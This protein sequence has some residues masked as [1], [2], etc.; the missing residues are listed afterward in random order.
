MLTVSD[1]L[2][3][4]VQLASPPNIYFALREV[5]ED[6]NKTVQDAA[7]VIESDAALAMKLLKIVNSAFYGFPAQISSIGKAISLIGLRELQNMVLAALVIERFSEL[8]GAQLS[9]HDFW[10]KNLRSAL[11]A[12]ELDCLCGKQYA[13]TA[14]LCGLVHNIG[15]LVFY[16]RIPLL[17]RQVD[18]ELQAGLQNGD[19]VAIQRQVIGLDQY[20][21]GSE[22]CRMWQLPEVVGESIA[23]HQQRD[24]NSPFADIAMIVSYANQLA[25]IEAV[26]RTQIP[27]DLNL[28][29]D[30]ISSLLDKTHEEFEVL[31][32]L[33]YRSH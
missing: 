10:A 7:I 9:I 17:A 26:S 20:Q 11:I 3:G 27:N 16:R 25:N 21:V 5:I 30:K 6:A 19:L 4:D 32:K 18:L 2:K 22:L 24:S 8:P 29:A 14:F 15:L 33:F 1:L 13:D 28:S 31:F 12:R 23:L